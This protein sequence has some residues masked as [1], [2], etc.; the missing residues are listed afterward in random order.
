MKVWLELH[1]IG[2][3][4][5]LLLLGPRVEEDI[6]FLLQVGVG[7]VEHLPPL[8]YPLLLGVYFI[9]ECLQHGRRV[10]EGVEM[11]HFYRIHLTPLP[12]YDAVDPPPL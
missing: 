6:G 3:L 9:G 4:S 11:F 5:G 1:E 8:P 10:T 7:G 12:C 2:P